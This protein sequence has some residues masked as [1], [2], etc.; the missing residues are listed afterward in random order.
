MVRRRVGTVTG[1]AELVA[2]DHR[3]GGAGQRGCGSNENQVSRT[4]VLS[5]LNVLGK[6][7][8]RIRDDSR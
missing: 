5:A 8:G 3:L 2:T 4:V 7:S 1:A 6:S